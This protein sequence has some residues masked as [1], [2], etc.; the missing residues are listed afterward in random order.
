[1][2]TRKSHRRGEFPPATEPLAT[3]VLDSHTHLDLTLDDDYAAGPTSVTDAIAWAAAAGIDRLVQ[4]GVDV[5]S[6]RWGLDVAR[7]HRAVVATVALHPNEAPR[8]PDL[9]KA[10]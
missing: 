1:M 8:V 5:P 2:S 9:G 10:L 7:Q 4:V 3:P 6:S